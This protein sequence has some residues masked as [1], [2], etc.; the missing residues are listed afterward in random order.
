MNELKNIVFSKNTIEFVTVAVQ[1]CEYIENF[2]EKT[3]VELSD[4]LTKFL[5]LL[6]LKVSL[7]PKTQLIDEFGQEI[8]VTEEDYNY[9]LSKLSDAFGKDDV[10]LEVF[11]E[12]MKYSETPISANISEDLSDIYQDVKNFVSIFEKGI[13]ENMNDALYICMETF[14][15]YWGQKLVNVLRALH[16]LKYSVVDEYGD[17]EDSYNE[18]EKW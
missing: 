4:K 17:D 16:S 14:S 7:L 12:D 15:S 18:E 2:P 13:E 10:Y 5:P 1:Y 6:Y 8:T 11:L 9:I 3:A